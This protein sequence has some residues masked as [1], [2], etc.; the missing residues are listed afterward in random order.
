MSWS[1]GVNGGDTIEQGG[2]AAAR[3]AHDSN[4]FSFIDRETDV[5]Y[6]FGHH[7]FVAVVFFYITYI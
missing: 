4:K 5:I 1:N 2:F 3:S 6:G 7:T